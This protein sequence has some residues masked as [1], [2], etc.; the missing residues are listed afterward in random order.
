MA[1][2][3]LSFIRILKGETVKVQALKKILLVEDELIVAMVTSK[4]IKNFNFDVITANTGEKAIEIAT[5][6]DEISLILMDIDLGKGIDGPEAALQILK[7][8]NIPIVFLTSHTEKEYVDRVKEIT[9]YGYVIKDS[10][11]F[12]LQSSIDMALELFEA[13]Q[14]TKETKDKLEATLDALP[15]MLFEAGEDGYCYDYHSP[16]NDS[17][18]GGPANIIGKTLHDIFHSSIADV[19]MSA[20]RET[21]EKGFSVGKQF[22]ISSNNGTLWFEI[23]VSRKF[24]GPEKNSFIILMRDITGRKLT[25]EDLRT[26]QIELKM[27]NDEFRIK[28]E[29]L[30]TLRSKYFDLYDLAPAGYLT[31]SENGLILEANLTAVTLLGMERSALVKM[32]VTRFIF[33]EDQDIYYLHSKRLLETGEPQSYALRML[34]PD[35]TTF[36]VYL[37]ITATK[38]NEGDPV[39]RMIMVNPVKNPLV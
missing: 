27:Q 33:K 11:D 6:N 23:S 13:N 16:N 7:K 8:R 26:H 34:R 14:K 25:E 38:Y 35:E 5:C 22:E 39:Y 31:L 30:E 21:H 15:D 17:I 20:I 9:R 4:T 2:K 24:S 10:G 32:P 18:F 12:V 28:Q 19:I 37:K 29:E 1:G 3:N 36:P